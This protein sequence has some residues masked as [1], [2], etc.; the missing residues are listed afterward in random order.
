MSRRSLFVYLDKHETPPGGGAARRGFLAVATLL[1]SYCTGIYCSLLRGRCTATHRTRPV[2]RHAATW[3]RSVSYVHKTACTCPLPNPIP[4]IETA[5]DDRNSC[6]SLPAAAQNHS[7][8]LSHCRPG[9]GPLSRPSF[10]A[11]CVGWALAP[12]E[13]RDAPAPCGLVTCAPRPALWR[14]RGPPSWA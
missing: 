12:H 7:M 13:R 4:S 1:S 9:T 14:A 5:P 3:L 11:R 2:P 6:K 10:G 8:L